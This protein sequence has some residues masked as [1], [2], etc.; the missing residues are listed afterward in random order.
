MALNGKLSP[1]QVGIEAMWVVDDPCIP[2]STILI[3]G[4][5]ALENI[6][7]GYL[8]TE[9]VMRGFFSNKKCLDE[10]SI[11]ASLLTRILRNCVVVI[12]SSD[13]RR[14]LG[15]DPFHRRYSLWKGGVGIY[16]GGGRRS[17]F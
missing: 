10:G 12:H 13:S 16:G 8:Y 4:R 14:E 7:P 5:L 1:L 2:S 11:I 15:T 9:N 6:L 17:V 3:R